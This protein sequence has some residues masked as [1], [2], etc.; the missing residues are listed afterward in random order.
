MKILSLLT[1]LLLYTNLFSNVSDIKST[2]KEVSIKAYVIDRETKKPVPYVEIGFLNLEKGVISDRNGLFE[3]KVKK[4][5]LDENDFLLFKSAGY[6][7]VKMKLSLVKEHFSKHQFLFLTKEDK[8]NSRFEFESTQ[9]VYDTKSPDIV[10]YPRFWTTNSTN[11]KE[12][13]TSLASLEMNTR[14]PL[15]YYLDFKNA[16]SLKV[17]LKFYDGLSEERFQTNDYKEV[18]QTIKAS[19]WQIIELDSVKLNS[20]E[21]LHI[22][23]QAV[24]SFDKDF[25]LKIGLSEDFVGFQKV[26]AHAK[27]DELPF[28]G[29]GFKVLPQLKFDLYKEPVEDKNEK[30]ISGIVT[31][32]GKPLNK[33]TIR[34][35]NSLDEVQSNSDGSFSIKADREDNLVFS[36]FS[37]PN[38]EVTI[39]DEGFLQVEMSRRYI[40]LDTVKISKK[41]QIDNLSFPEIDTPIGKIK[42]RTS[43]YANYTKTIDELNRAALTFSELIQGRFPGLGTAG[44]RGGFPSINAP[45][46]GALVVVDGVPDPLDGSMLDVNNVESVTVIPG[47]AGT[48]RY[49]TLGRYGVILVT[50]KVGSYADKAS[51]RKQ[52]ED[53]IFNKTYTQDNS[54]A[55]KL[56]DLQIFDFNSSSNEE[57]AIGKYTK[58]N[59][60]FFIESFKY[61]YDKGE[62]EL[63]IN[64]LDTLESLL[65]TNVKALKSLAFTYEEYNLFDKAFRIRKKI[66]SLQPYSIQSYLDL[67]Q[68]YTN[69]KKYNKASEIYTSIIENKIPGLTLD[70]SSV[71]LAEIKLKHLLTK[72]KMNLNLKHIDEIYYRVAQTFDVFVVIDWN[73]VNSSFDIQ[74]INS[75]NKYLSSSHNVV[76]DFDRLNFEN[77]TGYHTE[78]FIL[79]N[80]SDVDDMK[81]SLKGYEENSSIYNPSYV[82]FT[83]YRNYGS[84]DESREYKVINLNQLNRQSIDIASFVGDQL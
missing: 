31:R 3:L 35:N 52:I 8:N 13:V 74:Y 75:K 82:R 66:G 14:K 22:G 55:L 61:Y 56:D 36:H 30:R 33:A 59:V 71:E 29:V 76:S 41:K 50:T 4:S 6:F 69:S 60:P 28:F 20:F 51:D 46:G 15:M 58:Q 25:I 54:R 9:K 7:P 65:E 48:A 63:A 83:I 1:L 57:L 79:R 21:D 72:H 70:E 81:I 24:D 64:A 73:D 16:D 38:K 19:G 68:S 32:D 10:D 34:V 47:L 27:L 78:F 2:D 43:G 44:T 26:A 62:K 23:I 45:L 18:Y 80:Q 39:T 77:E 5:D 84:K 37:A 11:G 12:I 49:G 67:A 53:L 42:K 40:D 17:K